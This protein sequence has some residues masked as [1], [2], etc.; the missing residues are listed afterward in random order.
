VVAADEE[1]GG[2]QKIGD[3][4]EKLLHKNNIKGKNKH[5]GSKL[6]AKQIL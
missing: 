5:R 3:I 6:H 2:E 1:T 4:E